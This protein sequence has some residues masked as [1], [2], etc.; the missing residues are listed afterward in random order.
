M[1]LITVEKRFIHF[2]ELA[3][4]W[5]CIKNFFFMSVILEIINFAQ[6]VYMIAHWST[7]SIYERIYL[8]SELITLKTDLL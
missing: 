1:I 4:D 2:L 3:F 7:S 6:I 8:P 5:V